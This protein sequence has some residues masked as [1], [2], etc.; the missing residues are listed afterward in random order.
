MTDHL[1]YGGKY[2]TPVYPPRTMVSCSK[3]KLHHAGEAYSQS[4]RLHSTGQLIFA[5]TY[6]PYA[7]IHISPCILDIMRILAR[8]YA[9]WMESKRAV[10][11]MTITNRTPLEKSKGRDQVCTFQIRQLANITGV[12]DGESPR[13]FSSSFPRAVRVCSCYSNFSQTSSVC[14]NAHGMS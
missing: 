1:Q 9:Q 8:R 6:S 4:F 2:W 13:Q 7:A 3:R 12:Y 14:F 11:L 10:K 5:G